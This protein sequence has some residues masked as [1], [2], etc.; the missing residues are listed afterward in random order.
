MRKRAPL[1]VLLGVATALVLMAPGYAS[2]QADKRSPAGAQQAGRMNAAGKGGSVRGRT[3]ALDARLYRVIPIA[4]PSEDER[5]QPYLWRFWRHIPHDGHFTIYDRS[6]YGRILVE[7]VED[8]AHREARAQHA[9]FFFER[10]TGHGEE[11]N[12]H[13]GQP[14]YDEEGSE[15]TP[16]T[17]LVQPRHQRIER[18]GEECR[19]DEQQEPVPE[20][21]PCPGERHDGEQPEE[22]GKGNVDA[23]LDSLSHQQQAAEQQNKPG[24]AGCDCPTGAR[25]APDLRPA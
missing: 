7:R 14:Q 11:R 8:F 21:K 5:A 15:G 23:S 16:D 12:E 3:P 25:P 6:W 1:V 9:G 13:P 2:K 24:A 19:G 4:A 10:R 17:M 20:S 22:S 18:H